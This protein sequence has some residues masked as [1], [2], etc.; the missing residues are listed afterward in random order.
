MFR[1]INSHVKRGAQRSPGF[2]QEIEAEIERKISRALYDVFQQEGDYDDG[3]PQINKEMGRN[4]FN[5]AIHTDRTG[6][7][8]NQAKSIKEP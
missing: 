5:R 2:A 3:K 1:Q 7:H 6:S 8:K 4:V